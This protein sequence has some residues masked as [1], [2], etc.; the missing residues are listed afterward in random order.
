MRSS[1]LV[2]LLA[3]A[4]SSAPAST[5]RVAEDPP[6]GVGASQVWVLRPTGPI[7]SVVVFLHGWGTFSPERTPWIDHLRARGNAVV[8]PRYQKDVD[9]RA[10][11]TIYRLRDGLRRAFAQRELRNRPVVTVGISWGASLA[12]Q[13]GAQARVWGVPVPSAV[14]GL[15][16]ASQRFGGPPKRGLPRSVRVLLMVGDADR[17]SSAQTF[18]HWLGRHP[19][20]HKTFRVVRS[21]PTFRADHGSPT[22]STPAARRAYWVPLDEL[23]A[24]ARTASG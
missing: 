21:T 5:A 22:R 24:R 3:V 14:A 9:D 18:W 19:R 8:F 16:P 17:P 20:R 13:Y 15:N 7:R 2:G 10:T 23:V 1:L 4:L 12:F 6:L 11:S